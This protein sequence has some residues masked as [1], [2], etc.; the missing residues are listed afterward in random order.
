MKEY[1]WSSRGMKV[2]KGPLLMV[3]YLTLGSC[4]PSFSS[5]LEEESLSSLEQRYYRSLDSAHELGLEILCESRKESNSEVS[6]GT[7]GLRPAPK[8]PTHD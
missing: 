3:M 6:S 8:S 7:V 4:S 2:A 5:N 1:S